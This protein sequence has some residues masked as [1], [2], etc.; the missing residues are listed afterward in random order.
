MWTSNTRSVV[1]LREEITG[2]PKEMLGTNAPSIT[3]RWMY[4]APASET[5]FTSSPSFEK[6]AERIDGAKIYMILISPFILKFII[7]QP[8]IVIPGSCD[9]SCFYGILDTAFPLSYMDAAKEPA[10]RLI[11]FKLREIVF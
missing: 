2:I 7:D 8:V 1:F 4:C 10:F 5:V 9:L 3:S 6:S 11:G